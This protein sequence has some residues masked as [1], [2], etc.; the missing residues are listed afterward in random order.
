MI[1]EGKYNLLIELTAP[2]GRVV[3]CTNDL[4][5]FGEDLIKQLKENWQ[6]DT[7]SMSGNNLRINF[8]RF[9][10]KPFGLLESRILLIIRRKKE[11][12]VNGWPKSFC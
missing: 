12:T 7:Q 10:G 8:K 5:A 6:E 4:P 2:N 11:C 9:F 1:V 3:Q